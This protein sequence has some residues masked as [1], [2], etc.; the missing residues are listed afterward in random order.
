MKPRKIHWKTNSS[1]TLTCSQSKRVRGIC[2]GAN[3]YTYIIVLLLHAV[4]EAAKKRV[5][6]LVVRPLKGGG[7]RPDH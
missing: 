6:S 5:S 2:Y 7:G 4:R 3:K 1:G